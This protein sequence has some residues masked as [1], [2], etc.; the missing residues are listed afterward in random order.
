MECME[1][2][3]LWLSKF[4]LP[5]G[6]SRLEAMKL[7]CSLHIEEL[8]TVVYVSAN[9][10]WQDVITDAVSFTSVEALSFV[11]VAK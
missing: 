10:F 3:T 6:V 5:L 11:I 8:V 1:F 7:V 4:F 2:S 9:V